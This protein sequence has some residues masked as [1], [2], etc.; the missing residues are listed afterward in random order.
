YIDN[1]GCQKKHH[2]PQSGCPINLAHEKET[3][4]KEKALA[5]LKE[6][7]RTLMSISKNV[8]KMNDAEKE[9][10]LSKSSSQ[11]IK[12]DAQVKKVSYKYQTLVDDYFRIY[13]K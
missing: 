3:L 2:K 5:L 12:L 1:H 7:N 11:Y 6:M 9:K 8:V 4:N 10:L 13:Q